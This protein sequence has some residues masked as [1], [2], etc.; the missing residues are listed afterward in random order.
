[1]TELHIASHIGEYRVSQNH[2]N[3]TTYRQAINSVRQIHG[4]ARSRQDA[5]PVQE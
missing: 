1:M 4:I 5:K 2:G 3:A